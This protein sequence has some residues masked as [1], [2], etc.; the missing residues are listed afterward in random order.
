MNPISLFSL[1]AVKCLN[2]IPKDPD[3]QHIMSHT[4]MLEYI[5]WLNKVTKVG[6]VF[7]FVPDKLKTPEL[8]LAAVTKVG[9]L[10]EFVP[11]ELKTRKLCL[12]AVSNNGD[13]LEFVPEEFKTLELCLAAVTKNNGYALEFV[14]DELFQMGGMHWNL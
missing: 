10:L 12:V 4:K 9:W 5:G 8:C 2:T 3:F 13:A 6:W 11:D 7:E 14:P 1:S